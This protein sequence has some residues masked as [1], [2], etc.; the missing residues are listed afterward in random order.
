MNSLFN[1]LLE[2]FAWCT[3]EKPAA[4]LSP[5]VTRGRMETKDRIEYWTESPPKLWEARYRRHRSQSL[6]LNTHFAAFFEIY[7]S[8]ILLH[9]SDLKI[10]AKN[11]SKIWLKWNEMNV[12]FISFSQKSM[13]FAVFLRDFDNFLSEFHG[14]SQKITNLFQILRKNAR[15]IRKTPE[16][17]GSCAD[18]IRSVH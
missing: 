16:I 6:Q 4:G 5:A 11:A 12:H 9:R 15:K 3:F 14:Y 13:N 18:F 17:S 10:S 2:H 1:S 7:K 8:C